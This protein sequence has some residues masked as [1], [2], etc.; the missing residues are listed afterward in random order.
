MPRPLITPE[1]VVEFVIHD[2]SGHRALVFDRGAKKPW[3]RVPAWK[4]KHYH[5]SETAAQECATAWLKI[6]QA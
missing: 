4:C 3:N 2:R 1:V 6:R 5:R